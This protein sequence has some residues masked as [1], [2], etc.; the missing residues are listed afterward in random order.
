[1]I[2][3]KKNDT[4]VVIAGK[5]KGKKGK[6]LKV[7]PKENRALVEGLN[8]RIKH[9]KRRSGKQKGEIIK[10]SQPLSV[11]NLML[12]CSQ[13]GRGS[14]SGFL[15]LPDGAKRRMCRRCKQAI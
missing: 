14:R 15:R 9:A 12:F 6:V 13:C 4:V 5:D 7:F 2:R 3:I 11:S 10:I 1:M 8:L